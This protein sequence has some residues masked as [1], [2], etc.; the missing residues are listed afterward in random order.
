MAGAEH[1]NQLLLTAAHPDSHQQRLGGYLLFYSLGSAL[2]ATTTTTVFAEAGWAGSGTLGAAF[3]A[4]ALAA[5]AFGPGPATGRHPSPNGCH[6][7]PLAWSRLPRCRTVLAT[8]GRS[9][10]GKIAY[11]GGRCGPRLVP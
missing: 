1:S 3:G 9:V 10:S 2:G 6:S 4:W 8:A 7:T 11:R 5:S